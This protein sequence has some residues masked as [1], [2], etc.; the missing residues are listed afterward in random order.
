MVKNLK[1]AKIRGVESHGMILAA[2]TPDG[3]LAIVTTDR[4]S[5]PGIRVK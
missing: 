5:S 3:G 4:P 1:P 2:G